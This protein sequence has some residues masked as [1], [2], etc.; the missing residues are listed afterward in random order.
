M[1]RLAWLGVLLTLVG[2]TAPLAATASFAEPTPA[3]FVSGG[4]LTAALDQ[5]LQD[6]EGSYGVLIEAQATSERYDHQADD[7]FRSASVYKLP[8]AVEVLRRVD[9][10]ELRLDDQ[11]TIA[12]QDATEGEPLG[13]VYPGETIT[14]QQALE[15]IT[16]VSSNAAAHALMRLIGR[17]ELDQS[18]SL[19]GWHATLVPRT[20]SS[21]DS[22]D[23]PAAVTSAADMADL[24]DRLLRGQLLSVTNSL[25]LLQL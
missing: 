23:A 10:H 8:L 6:Q 12:D 18:W 20:E 7:A 16:G 13:G 21:D 9:R 2:L 5:L 15:L 24:L 19:L 14:V 1:P 3:P 22:P 11:L 17:S 25:L 4:S